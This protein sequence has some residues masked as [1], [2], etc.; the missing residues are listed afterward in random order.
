[1]LDINH[2]LFPTDFSE[3]AAPAFPRAVHFAEWHDAT[4]HILNVRQSAQPDDLD[5]TREFPIPFS[6]MKGW[7]DQAA[8]PDGEPPSLMDVDVEQ[9]QL[10]SSAPAETIV[11]YVEDQNIDLVVMGTHGRR[12]IDRVRYGSVTEEVVRTAP[13]PVLTVRADGPSGVRTVRR[14]LAPVDFSDASKTALRHAKEIA[15]TYGAEIDLL[16]VVD[17][18]LYPSVY[19]IESFD[20]PGQKVVE[21]A[22]EGLAA[23]ARDIIGVE[24]AMVKA[25]SGHPVEEILSYVEDNEVDLLVIATHGRT[26]LNRVLLGSVAERVLRQSPIPVF[27]VKPEQASLLTESTEEGADVPTE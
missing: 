23:L 21:E 22:E 5:T 9:T 25:V 19:E 13:A 2:V 3:G 6:T 7:I 4:L 26:G 11:G 18:P 16:H 20:F 12:G 17:E 8:G 27:L 24:H 1:M 10:D 14:V 15:L